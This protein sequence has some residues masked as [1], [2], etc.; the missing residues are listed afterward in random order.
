MCLI[1]CAWA[2]HSELDLVVAANRDERH[3]RPT[4]AAHWWDAPSGLFAG[5]DLRA[6][7]TWCGIGTDG[8][9]AAVTNV[10]EPEA[11]PGR[12]SRGVLVRNYFAAEADAATW[13][14][15]SND[16]G[17]D[18]SPFNLLV[19]DR[20]NL[21]FV[22]NRGA[23]RQRRLRP[24]VYAISNGHWGDRWPKTEAAQARL[25]EDLAA[26]RA[27]PETL[28]SWLADTEPASWDRLPD[29]GVGPEHERLLS[30]LFIRSPTYGTRAS[31]VIRRAYDG[32]I[33]FHERGF[34]HDA[35]PGHRVDEHWQ[36]TKECPT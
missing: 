32:R 3:D 12:L 17:A 9:F 22:S 6:G 31:T 15:W 10:R 26:G 7:G 27:D 33:D 19:G 21:W 2:A 30:P 29:T 23:V 16:H 4:A 36:I 34:D 28:F 25:R 1:A 35:N 11:A 14:D 24:G 18:F 20:H 5:K 13:A 8:R